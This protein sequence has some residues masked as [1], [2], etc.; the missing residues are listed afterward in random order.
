MERNT[1]REDCNPKTCGQRGPCDLCG[2]WRHAGYTP[3]VG[4][5]GAK[6]SQREAYG[7]LENYMVPER[8]AIGFVLLH[9]GDASPMFHDLEAALL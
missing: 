1:A 8:L 6:R 2:V 7:V 9:G 4:Y 5:E 3:A